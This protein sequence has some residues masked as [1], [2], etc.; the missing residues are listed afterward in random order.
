MSRLLLDTCVWG[1]AVPELQG[2]GHEVIWTGAWEVDPGDRVIL[3]YAHTEERILV[4]L[5]KDFGELAILKGMP[6]SGIIRLANFRA[7]QMGAAIHH[8]VNRFL[9]ELNEGA[10]VTADPEKIRVRPG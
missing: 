6:H 5:D 3:E 7:A 8:L 1:G 2:Y 9:I 10:I 4:T